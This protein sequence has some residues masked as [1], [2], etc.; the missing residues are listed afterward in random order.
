MQIFYLIISFIFGACMGSFLNVVVER[1]QAKKSF[2]QGRSQCLHCGKTLGILDL[3]PIFSFL[4]LRGRCRY[5]HK[6][7]SWQYFCMEL[8][9]GI[10]FGLIYLN[11]DNI[12]LLIFILIISCF[13]IIIFLYDYKYYLI[14]DRITI[15]AMVIALG[16]NLLLGQVWWELLLGAGIAGGFFLLQYLISQG[17]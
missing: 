15:P 8:I 5:C 4:F 2:L 16:G 17:K 3:V 12:F 7:I 13:L 14:L 11:I 9:T 1:L 10:I 6:K